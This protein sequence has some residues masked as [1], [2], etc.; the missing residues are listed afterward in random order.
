MKVWVLPAAMP[1]TTAN[2]V[3]STAVATQTCNIRKRDINPPH[4]LCTRYWMLL[5]GNT[6]SLF[7]LDNAR[8]SGGHMD[9]SGF[10]SSKAKPSIVRRPTPVRIAQNWLE[11]SRNLVEKAAAF[12]ARQRGAERIGECVQPP[13]HSGRQRRGGG[14]RMVSAKSGPRS[15]DCDGCAAPRFVHLT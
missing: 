2:P 8:R 15:A 12:L 11:E 10:D 1:G 3:L 4:V 7:D 6:D 5:Q 13:A 14:W 9:A